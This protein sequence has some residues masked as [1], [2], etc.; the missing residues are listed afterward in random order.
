MIEPSSSHPVESLQEKN[1]PL[2]NKIKDRHIITPVNEKQNENIEIDW[3]IKKSEAEMNKMPIWAKEQYQK[4]MEIEAQAE[5]YKAN[6]EYVKSE[7]KFKQAI[8]KVE[9]ILEQKENIL[10]QS[11]KKGLEYL[12]EE[13]LTQS[14]KEFIK[15]SAIDNKVLI[16]NRSL[17]RISNRP[18]V[19]ELYQK[20]KNYEKKSDTNNAIKMLENALVIEPEYTKIEKKLQQ[21]LLKEKSISFDKAIGQALSALDKKNYTIA[22]NEIKKAHSLSSDDPIIQDIEQRISEGIISRKI[23]HMISSAKKEEKKEQWQEAK[24]IY[25]NILKISPDIG[26]IIVKQERVNAYI[27]LN[28][29]IDNI[30][31]QTERLQNDKI[32]EKSKRAL[33]YVRNELNQNSNSYYTIMKTPLLMQKIASAKEAINN[34]SK[35][36]NV[37]IHSDN[38]TDITIYRVS[39]IGKLTNKQIKLRPGKYTIVGTRIGYRDFRKTIEITANDQSVIINVQCKEKI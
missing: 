4:T 39:K 10:Q 14:K 28:Q 34:A 33:K 29:L 1:K 8:K 3:M 30:V 16:I 6:K 11:I 24:I 9:S 5:E 32:F 18:K 31:N 37:T 13:N 36:I 23:N 19:L 35:Q 25:N 27:Q 15:A 21:L 26:Q 2:I 7:E 22:R 38:R 12:E 17:A 20:S